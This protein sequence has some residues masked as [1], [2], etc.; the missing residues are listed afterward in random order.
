MNEILDLF[1]QVPIEEIGKYVQIS[2]VMLSSIQQEGVYTLFDFWVKDFDE[3]VTAGFHKKRAKEIQNVFLN[4]SMKQKKDGIDFIFWEKERILPTEYDASRLI[5]EN[6]QLVLEEL[7]EYINGCVS[8][9]SQ[10]YNKR[11]KERVKNLQSI[12]RGSYVEHLSRENVANLI[13]IS[14]ERIRQLLFLELLD[15]LF[16]GQTLNKITVLKRLSINKDLV[17]KVQ[18]FRKTHMF[19]GYQLNE[20]CDVGFFEDVLHIDFLTYPPLS[21]IVPQREKLC[22]KVVLKG[23]IDEMTAVMRGKPIEELEEIIDQNQ[24]IQR[25]IYKKHKTY[26]EGFI[27]QLLYDDQIIQDTESGKLIRPEYIRNFGTDELGSIHQERALARIIADQS[28]AIRKEN[29]IRIY[30][31]RY[32]QDLLGQHNLE[33]TIKYGCKAIGRTHWIYNQDAIPLRD[34]IS[35]YTANIGRPFT[36]DEV[37][38]AISDGAIVYNSDATIRTYITEYCAVHCRNSDKFCHRDIVPQQDDYKQWRERIRSGVFNWLVNEIHLLFQQRN[39]DQL[40]CNDIAKY[41]VN[42]ANAT[43]DIDR[44]TVLSYCYSLPTNENSPFEIESTRR[45]QW[46]LCKSDNYDKTDWL[47]Y[48]LRGRTYQRKMMNEATHIIRHTQYHQMPLSELTRSMQEVIGD[49]IYDDNN[50]PLSER[51]IRQKLIE[52]IERNEVNHHLQLKKDGDGKLLVK[53]D[54]RRINEE[55]RYVATSTDTVIQYRTISDLNELNWDE[56]KSLLISELAICKKWMDEDDLN[57]EYNKVVEAFVLFIKNDHNNNL[58]TVMPQKLYEFFVVSNPT[59]ID[60]YCIMCNIAKNYEALLV[61]IAKR[62]YNIKVDRENPANGIYQK[63]VRYNFEDI[64]DILDN[65]TKIQDLAQGSYQYALKNLNYVR[66]ADSHGNWYLDKYATDNNTEDERNIKK[67][68]NFAALYIFT[69][70]KYAMSNVYER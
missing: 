28:N 7:L 40:D 42:R 55:Q 5:E 43:Y 29:I 53:L 6:L 62:I 59:S 13:G 35:N 48:G 44:N 18:E 65:T 32:G 26:D 41:V 52:F 57:I 10:I 37:K 15:P 25:E 56:L 24:I 20:N 64:T 31:Q 9:E 68:L 66:N 63:S 11:D 23:F 21:Y 60:R 19:K 39:V 45:G 12:L 61:S 34:W 47:N 2:K 8:R 51:R 33:P 1:K 69:Y 58:S 16:K 14:R 3:V 30:N 54:A 36:F 4:L 70:A 38:Q 49:D 46:F 67:I 22:Y 50:E 27:Y 17:Q